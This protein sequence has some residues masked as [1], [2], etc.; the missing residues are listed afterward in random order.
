MREFFQDWL[1]SVSFRTQISKIQDNVQNRGKK[2]LIYEAFSIWSTLYATKKAR[3]EQ[4]ELVYLR[5][6]NNLQFRCFMTWK[7]AL[8]ALRREKMIEKN[9]KLLL[10]WNRWKQRK[11]YR[12]GLRRLDGNINVINRRDTFQYWF[13]LFKAVE[14]CRLTKEKDTQQMVDD[15]QM[16]HTIRWWRKHVGK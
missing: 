10:F 7:K 5:F 11:L 14:K 16:S 8:P 6:Q 1:A 3:K 13:Q 12:S 2:E 15:F 9:A 4:Y